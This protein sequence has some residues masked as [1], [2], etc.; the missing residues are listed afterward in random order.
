MNGQ[1]ISR[2]EIGASRTH[3]L[4]LAALQPHCGHFARIQGEQRAI[5]K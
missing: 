2:A 5:R 3:L 1:T 4:A